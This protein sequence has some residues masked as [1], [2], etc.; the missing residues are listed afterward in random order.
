MMSDIAPPTLSNRG[1]FTTCRHVILTVLLSIGSLALQAAPDNGTQI[2]TYHQPDGST[3]GVK[4][5]GDEFF[6][7]ERT[8]D[9]RHVIR[10]PETGY[11]CYA[12]LSD[13]GRS[14]VSTGV[15]VVTARRSTQEAPPEAKPNLTLPMDAVMAIVRAN[16]EKAGVDSDGRPKVD[17]KSVV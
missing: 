7:Y 13:D 16:Q 4:I 2:H 5:Y 15:P 9:G 10:D 3:F 14:F 6:A 12:K 11:S 8:L 17:R 1:L